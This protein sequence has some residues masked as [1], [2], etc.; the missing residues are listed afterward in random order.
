MMSE[1]STIAMKTEILMV[2]GHQQPNMW[3]REEGQLGQ[4]GEHQ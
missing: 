1:D 4:E 2:R 3:H